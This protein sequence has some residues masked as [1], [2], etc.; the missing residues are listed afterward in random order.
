MKFKKC[1]RMALNMVFHSKLRSWLTIL[2]IVIGVASVIAI[3]GIGEGLNQ[4]ITSNLGDLEADIITI[5]PGYSQAQS[6]GPGRDG[7]GPGGGVSSSSSSTD[8]LTDKDIQT[9]KGINEIEIISPLISGNVDLEYLGEEGSVSLTGVDPK[10]YDEIES[11]EILEGRTLSSSDSNVILIGERLSTQ[12]FEKEIK[13]NQLLSIESKS[14][15]V[16][17]IIEDGG[18]SIIMPIDSAFSVLDV[19]EDEYDSI[20]VRIS[21]VDKLNQTEEEIITDLMRSRHVDED[22][23][24]FSVKT[25][26][27]SNDFR[28][29][30]TSTLTSFLTGIAAI[31]LLVGAVG[32]ANTMFT[33]VLEKTK[34]IGIMKSIGAK[35]GDILTIFILNSA[36]I[37][38]VGGVLGTLIGYLVSTILTFVGLTS[39]ITLNSVIVTLFI[40][41]F[42][43]V[44]SGFIPAVNASKLDPVVALRRD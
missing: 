41:I 29:E 25:N 26:T 44:L 23:R 4:Q 30:M 28:A 8:P 42:V 21:D 10:V 27:E 6:F 7:G 35:N 1:F 17:G 12:Y 3:V 13:L 9:L 11:P 14:F 39:I 43:G 20:E 34:D 37:G 32:I 15:R 40:S 5:T 31:S 2:G 33:S 18:N 19:E 16:V 24:D 22:D 36:L 38:L